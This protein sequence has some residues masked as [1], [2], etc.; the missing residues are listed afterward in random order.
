MTKRFVINISLCFQDMS[1]PQMCRT[2]LFVHF[3]ALLHVTALQIKPSLS[4]TVPE[5]IYNAIG[6]CTSVHMD[7][8]HRHCP[9]RLYL[10]M[11]LSCRENQNNCLLD[12]TVH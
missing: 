9:Q 6:N 5:K 2:N 8:L 3:T 12:Q 11:H 7:L 10:I 4:D 1:I